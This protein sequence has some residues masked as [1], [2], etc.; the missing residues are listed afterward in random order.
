MVMLLF[1]MLHSV[2]EPLNRT[3]EEKIS[4]IGKRP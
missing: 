4:V 2:T 3:N 1:V